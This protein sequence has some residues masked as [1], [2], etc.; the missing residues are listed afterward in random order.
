MTDQVPQRTDDDPVPTGFGT[1][2]NK[3]KIEQVISGMEKDALRLLRQR[4]TSTVET[5]SPVIY[6]TA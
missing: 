1:D 6:G 2:A 5:P 4:T 3:A